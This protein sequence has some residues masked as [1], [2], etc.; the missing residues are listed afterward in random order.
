MNDP[1][2]LTVAREA[3][4]ADIRTD[5]AA[6]AR[7]LL[8]A[9]PLDPPARQR[10]GQRAAALVDSVRAARRSFGGI[11]DFLQEYGLDTRYGGALMCLAEALLRVPDANNADRLIAD[12]LVG[13]DWERYLGRSDSLFVTPRPGPCC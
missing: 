9:W 3:L 11:D 1:T 5:E 6:A 13:V 10:V 2:E 4:R 8:E 7:A 12:K